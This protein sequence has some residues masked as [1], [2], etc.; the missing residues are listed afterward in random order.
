MLTILFYQWCEARFLAGGAPCPPTSAI[1][2]GSKIAV[3]LGQRNQIP[4]I[5][6]IETDNSGNMTTVVTE[7]N[8]N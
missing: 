5:V 2:K 1:N 3:R 4:E 6:E 8:K 7:I